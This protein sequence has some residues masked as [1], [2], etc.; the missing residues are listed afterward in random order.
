[1]QN[2]NTVTSTPKQIV[3]GF[4]LINL[5]VVSVAVSTMYQLRLS[6]DQKAATDTQNLS[7]VLESSLSG[8][9]NNIDIALQDTID[10][11]HHL[12][13]LSSHSAQKI[14]AFIV[15]QKKHVPDLLNIRVTN[16]KGDWLYGSD[17][18]PSTP[19]NYADRDYFIQH[20]DSPNAGLVV[21]APLFGKT[22]KVWLIS[23]ARRINKPDGSFGGV[24][25]GSMRLDHLSELLSDIDVGSSGAI[26][27][28]NEQLGLLARRPQSQ[29]SNVEIGSNKISIPFSQALRGNPGLGSYVSGGTS[30]DMVSRMHS[31]RKFEHYPFY[32]NVGLAEDDYLTA[33]RKGLWVA[34]AFV[35]TFFLTTALATYWLLRL[36]RQQLKTQAKLRQQ[37][38]YLRAIIENEPECVKVVAPNGRLIE[39]NA[40]GLRMLEVDSLEEAQSF[41]LLEFI[42]PEHREPFIALHKNVIAGNSGKLEFLIKGKKGTVRW[43]DTHAVPLRNAEGEVINLLG[44]TR[45]ITERKSFQHQLEHQAHVDYLTGVNNRG[46]FVHLAEIE[47]ARALRYEKR[48]SICMLDI[49]LFKQVNDTHG[50]KIGD[51]V[52]IR[53]AEVC[54]QTLREI[55][56]IGRLGGEE[57]AIL[58]PETDQKEAAEV[59][60]RLRLSIAAAR[61]PLND[62]LPITITVSIGVASLASSDDNL[63]V[64]MNMADKALYQAKNSGR[65]RVCTAQ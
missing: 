42:D 50:H 1:M 12:K 27:L 44:I 47:L 25:Y 18:S 43:L 63:D 40:A 51:L 62:G 41:G 14:N 58:L 11:I 15:Q 54:K 39:M 6:V 4:V 35:M 20:R 60:E 5:L 64:L 61:I 31:Y 48:L 34:V 26:A 59:A 2:L 56:V 52:L 28:R 65:N 21:S 30:I 33:W 9:F 32:I 37:R 3:L 7:R 17:Y 29:L 49:D 38:E 45:D 10:E 55:D 24:V 8:V 57:F 16:E 46:H 22:T 13:S 19:A 53:L 23:F 36:L